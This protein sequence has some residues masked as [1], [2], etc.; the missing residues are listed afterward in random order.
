MLG[1][2]CTSLYTTLSP[3]GSLS[4]RPPSSPAL[5]RK[6]GLHEEV[7][8]LGSVHASVSARSLL[9]RSRSFSIASAIPPSILLSNLNSER[10]KLD[11]NPFA[12]ALA[13][14][15][16]IRF[17]LK[18]SLRSEELDARASPNVLAPASPISLKSNLSSS[19]EDELSRRTAAHAL[20]PSSRIAFELRSTHSTEELRR[21]IERATALAPS[22]RMTLKLKST[23][24]TEASVRRSDSAI[25]SAS[26]SPRLRPDRSISVKVESFSP[27]QLS[28]R[29]RGSGSALVMV[30][31][32]S[33][34]KIQTCLFGSVRR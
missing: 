11:R 29:P 18:S 2:I 26:S 4:R 22:F 27:S 10:V 19:S 33:D 25:R 8:T 1:C 17:H 3:T 20:A 5:S 31:G 28:T 32:F 21:I 24:F 12:K 9:L 15:S 13:P 30:V 7:A 34:R 23:F 16:V 6:T 14:S